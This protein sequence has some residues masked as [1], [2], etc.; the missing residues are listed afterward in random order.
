MRYSLYQFSK[1]KYAMKYRY[2]LNHSRHGFTLI[3]VLIVITVIAILSL[4]VIPALLSASRRA[5]ESSMIANLHQLRDAVARFQAD[6]GMYPTALT[7]VE[8]KDISQVKSPIPPT[9]F[10]GA[11]LSTDGGL[12]GEGAGLPPNPFIDQKENDYTNEISD[13]GGSEDEQKTVAGFG[14]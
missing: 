2:A 3:E 12:Q 8:A 7:D 4:I 6:T 9:T 14:N 10:R 11:Y 1:G 13:G 5:R